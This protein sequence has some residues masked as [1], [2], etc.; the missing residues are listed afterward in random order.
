MNKHKAVAIAGL[1]LIGGSFARTIKRRTGYTVIGYDISEAAVQAAKND[2]VLDSCGIDA[3][4]D[5]DIVLIALFPEAAVEFAQNNSA[6]FKPGA[7]IVDLCGVKRR[8]AEGI[9]AALKTREDVCYI[10]GHPMAGR[11]QWGYQSATENLFDN[12][13]MILTPSPLL[14]TDILNHTED[15]FLRLGFRRVT[16]TTPERH[17]EMIALTS[18]LAHIVS[19]AYAQNP[20]AANFKGFSA[21]SFGDM[22][23]VARLNEVMWTELF[24]QNSD[25][26]VSQLDDITD[27]LLKFRKY[28]A[29]ND[30]AGL[31]CILRQ[32]REIKENMQSS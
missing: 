3:F 20:L 15:F 18:Q 23:R 7:V 4:R 5:A 19:S 14:P 28:L 21:G 24:L 26:L 30:A 32:G 17:D 12:A 11:E 9:S 22:T 10:G 31:E 2:G 1:G 16:L 27:R 13:S 6:V 25:N 8:V 29:E